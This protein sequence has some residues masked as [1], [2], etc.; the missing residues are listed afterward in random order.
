VQHNEMVLVPVED[1]RQR[2]IRQNVGGHP[3]TDGAEAEFL[4]RLT[5]AEHGDSLCGGEA[6]MRESAK[7]ILASVMAAEHRKA[8]YAALH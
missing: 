1:A 4:R 5:Y 8:R 3:A 2:G 6:I 7:G